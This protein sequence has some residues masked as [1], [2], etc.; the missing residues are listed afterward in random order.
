V[1]PLNRASVFHITDRSPAE[2]SQSRTLRQPWGADGEV[3]HLKRPC[4][5]PQ[6][7]VD[8]SC[9]RFGAGQRGEDVHHAVDRDENETAPPQLR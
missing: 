6:Q 9:G 7:G 8:K 1:T 5:T 2:T 4:S 3:A